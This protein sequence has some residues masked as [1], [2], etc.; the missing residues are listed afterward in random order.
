MSDTRTNDGVS[1]AGA[2]AILA[3][4]VAA[5][6]L[7]KF[8]TLIGVDMKTGLEIILRLLVPVLALAYFCYQHISGNSYYEPTI[9]LGNTWPL[10]VGSVFWAF[11]PAVDYKAV[12]QLP[13][14]MRDSTSFSKPW[15]AEWYGE[16][17]LIILFVVVS[18]LVIKIIDDMR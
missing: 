12:G 14:F 7:W 13:D 16:Y 6:L 18:Y 2:V 10:I 5:F 17:G 3:C 15:W 9:R 1:A 4:L 11:I 8:S